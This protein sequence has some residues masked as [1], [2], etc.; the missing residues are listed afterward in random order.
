ME[1]K[2]SGLGKIVNPIKGL[3]YFTER[4][5]PQFFSDRAQFTITFPNIL[6]A[7]QQNHS[8]VDAYPMDNNDTQ[9]DTQDCTKDCTKEITERQGVIV[10]ILGLNAT[11]TIPEIARKTSIS[12]RTV[13]SE[14]KILQELGVLRRV[15]GR[16]NGYWEVVKKE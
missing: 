4:M 11:I 10:N 1:R 8:K 5:L 6:L 14:I 3:S 13:K 15:G 2:G 9:D 12:E 7:W 16:K